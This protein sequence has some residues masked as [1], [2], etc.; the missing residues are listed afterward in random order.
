MPDEPKT[1]SRPWRRFLRFSVR[2]MIV[3]VLVVGAGLGWLVRSARIQREAV[4]AITTAHGRVLYDWEW[5]NGRHTPDGRPWRPRWL[6]DR[7]GVDHFNHVTKVVFPR[8]ATDAEMAH[9]GNLTLVDTLVFDPSN[10]SDL[11]LAHLDRL[12][13][14]RW[15]SISSASSSADTRIMRLKMLTRLQGLNLD[16]SDVTDAGL[17]HLQSFTGLELLGLSDTGITDEGLAHLKGLTNLRWLDL[18]GTQVTDAGL[19]QLKRL[20]ELSNLFLKGTRVTDAGEKELKQA[21]P[22]LKIFR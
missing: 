5:N 13:S 10:V 21:L 17:T 4:A 8:D 16:G 9:L 20:T 1:V 19:A 18:H 7:Q 22:S 11:G 3:L 15:L 12:T 2:G 14:L 6:V